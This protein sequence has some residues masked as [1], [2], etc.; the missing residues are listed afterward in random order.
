MITCIA[1]SRAT[2]TSTRLM[3]DPHIED[4]SCDGYDLPIF[5]Y[6]D[7]YTDIETNVAY[8]ADELNDSSSSW[9]S[10]PVGTSPSRPCRLDDA[11]GRLPY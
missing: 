9:P 11:P 5:V 10:G 7:G 3:H 4:I 1:P 2:V 6:H 8:D